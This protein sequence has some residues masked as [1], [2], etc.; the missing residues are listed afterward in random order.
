[1]QEQK[2]PV[3]GMMGKGLIYQHIKGHIEELYRVTPLN[4]T[5]EEHQLASCDMLVYCSDTWAPG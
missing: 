2:E 5:C 3:I 1:M 4:M